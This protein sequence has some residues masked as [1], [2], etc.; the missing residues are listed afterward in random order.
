MYIYIYIYTYIYIYIYIYIYVGLS[1]CF[2]GKR[3]LKLC[4]ICTY[5]SRWVWFQRLAPESNK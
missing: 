5:L 2:F 4:G 1:G 3:R